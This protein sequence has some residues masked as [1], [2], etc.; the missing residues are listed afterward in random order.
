MTVTIKNKN[1]AAA[2]RIGDIIYQ[3]DSRQGNRENGISS[4]AVQINNCKIKVRAQLPAA[5]AGGARAVSV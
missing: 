3:R 5:A 2:A 1:T 4:G